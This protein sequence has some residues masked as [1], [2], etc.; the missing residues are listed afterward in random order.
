MLRGTIE[1]GMFER[2]R[3][4]TASEH[5]G[6]AEFGD[7]EGVKRI[8]QEARLLSVSEEEGLEIDRMARLEEGL[9]IFG[10]NGWADMDIKGIEMRIGDQYQMG[11]KRKNQGLKQEATPK[12][13]ESMKMKERPLTAKDMMTSPFVPNQSRFM[14]MLSGHESQDGPD[15]ETNDHSFQP[16]EFGASIF[17]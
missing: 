5:S 16:T 4:M 6:V 8:I 3:K 9:Q 14:G 2:A 10:R 15:G 12:E 11:G 13:T 7:D 1:E 17:G